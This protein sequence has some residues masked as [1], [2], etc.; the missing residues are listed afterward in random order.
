MRSLVLL[1]LLVI[2]LTYFPDNGAKSNSSRCGNTH[3]KAVI[4]SLW[5]MTPHLRLH[6]CPPHTLPNGFWL[7]LLA[8]CVTSELPFADASLTSVGEDNERGASFGVDEQCPIVSMLT[9]SPCTVKVAHL[10][11]RESAT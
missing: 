3:T 8:I 4:V 11:I 1:S 7:L 5:R 6:R 10:N 2:R 9:F